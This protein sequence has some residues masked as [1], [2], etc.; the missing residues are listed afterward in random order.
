MKTQDTIR[1][2]ILGTGNMAS[3]LALALARLPDAQVI[4]VASRSQARAESF[5]DGAGI[6]RRYGSYAA[7]LD[8]P[9]VDVVYVATPHTE[10]HRNTLDAL[11][12]GKHVLCEKPFAINAAEAEEMIAAARERRLFLMEGV[13]MRFLPLMDDLRAL[14]RDGAIGDVRMFLADFGFQAEFDPKSRLFDPRLAGGSLLDV[15]IYPVNMASLLFGRPEQIASVAHIGETGVDEQAAM[16]LRYSGGRLAS[17]TSSIRTDTPNEAFIC[18]SEG[19]IRIHRRW[20]VPEIMTVT[21]G[22]RQETIHRPMVGNGYVH[23]AEEV[24]RCIREGRTESPLMPLDETLAIMRTLDDLRAQ[25]GL[26]YPQ[27]RAA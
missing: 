17:L 7:L 22:A 12:A 6:P 25:W 4:A 15:G 18:G 20:W 2:G 5:A 16:V 13:W 9:D 1:W 8:D 26:V 19:S 10:H 11:R 14:L 23:E 3:Q 24:M 21:A 27:E